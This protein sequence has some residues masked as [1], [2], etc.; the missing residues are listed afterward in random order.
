MRNDPCTKI[1]RR[2]ETTIMKNQTYGT[3]GLTR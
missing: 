1:D 3:E 2:K